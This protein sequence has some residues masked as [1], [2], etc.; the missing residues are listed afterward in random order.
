[1]GSIVQRVG[2]VAWGVAAVLAAGGAA[3][4]C[5][6]TYPNCDNDQHCH[7]GEFCVN[8]RCQDCRSDSDCGSGQRCAAGACEAIP[9]FCESDSA[10]GA[11]EECV[12]N[13]CRRRLTTSSTT[14]TE[15]RPAGPCQ[16][17]PTYFSFEDDALDDAA[18]RVLEANA[19][20][21]QERSIPSVMVTGHC[22]PRG[23]EEYNLALGT[24]RANSTRD[25]LQRLGVERGHIRTTSRGEEDA[26]GE[27]ESGWARDRRADVSER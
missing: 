25:H 16:L 3:V 6:P 12:G 9:G 4:G 20:C 21:I 11:D 22:D 18:R 8:G 17:Q 2:L 23:T 27:D 1:M 26:T 10:C 24:R 7:E 13:R 15:T 19:R 14:D 5:G